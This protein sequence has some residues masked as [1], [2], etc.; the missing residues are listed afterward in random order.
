MYDPEDPMSLSLTDC[1]QVIPIYNRV[2]DCF[3]Q[4]SLL[5]PKPLW[6]TQKVVGQPKMKKISNHG[7]QL[8]MQAYHILQ[9]CKILFGHLWKM[10][11][12][13]S[14]LRKKKKNM[15]KHNKSP[16]LVWETSKN[17]WIKGTWLWGTTRW[18]LWCIH[19]FMV[20]NEQSSW[21]S[22]KFTKLKHQK[23]WWFHRSL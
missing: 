2:Y 8:D 12:T 6:P 14:E 15:S 16:N 17:L 3:P 7:V 5:D 11:W 23:Q 18:W 9:F 20:I 22:M 19:M 13:N 4:D 1:F 21:G 10:L